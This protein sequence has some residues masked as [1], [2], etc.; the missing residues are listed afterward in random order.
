MHVPRRVWARQSG[1]AAALFLAVLLAAA[2]AVAQEQGSVSVTID[3]STVK[4]STV[5]YKPTGE[6][7]FP[8]MIFHHGSGLIE[9]PYDP[10]TVASWFV[11]RGWA[12]I[13]PSRRGRGG[14]QGWDEEG[15][16]CSEAGAVE[17]AD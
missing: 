13:A 6:G 10:R 12:V 1:G 7:P 8:T 9:R 3:G 5:T 16:T 4:L 17:G 11:A 14:S 15:S 2:P